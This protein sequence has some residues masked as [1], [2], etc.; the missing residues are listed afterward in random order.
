LI[1]GYN[2][3]PTSSPEKI[4]S[5]NEIT[6]EPSFMQV[7]YNTSYSYSAGTD[8]SYT[9]PAGSLTLGKAYNV[10]VTAKEEDKA[11]SPPSSAITFSVVGEATLSVTSSSVRLFSPGACLV[12]E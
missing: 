1:T 12:K 11:D 2:A 9:I 6:M 8:L 10:T 4:T 3:I 5:G 7:S